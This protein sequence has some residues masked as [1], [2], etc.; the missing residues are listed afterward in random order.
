MVYDHYVQFCSDYR[1]EPVN[2]ASFGKFI[3][4][5]FPGIKTRRL[6]TRG[7]SKYHYCGIRP[8]FGVQPSQVGT[9]EGSV[10]ALAAIQ[11]LAA[12]AAGQMSIPGS[13][14]VPTPAA[15]PQTPIVFPPPAQGSSS[16]YF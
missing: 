15:M 5:V 6:G 7:K 10:S 2:S 1:V 11:Q 3:R 12:A 8:R 13:P 16:K 4:A 14:H 9:P